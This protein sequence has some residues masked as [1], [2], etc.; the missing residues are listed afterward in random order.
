MSFR[1][2]PELARAIQRTAVDRGISVQ[3]LLLVALRDAGVPVLDADLEDLRQGGTSGSPRRHSFTGQSDLRSGTSDVLYRRDAPAT[4][5]D[6]AGVIAMLAE[7]FTRD[8]PAT[9]SVV[10]NCGCPQAAADVKKALNR[11]NRKKGTD[12]V[13]KRN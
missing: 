12:D 13:I 2:R 10:V 11:P 7:I 4:G 8:R 5:P 1:V 6:L 3:T 9:P